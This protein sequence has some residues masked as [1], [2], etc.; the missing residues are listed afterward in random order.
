MLASIRSDIYE[1]KNHITSR[2]KHCSCY[3]AG[4]P[5]EHVVDNDVALLLE[6]LQLGGTSDTQPLAQRGEE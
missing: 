3:H 1:K 6:S 4:A 5:G 2:N